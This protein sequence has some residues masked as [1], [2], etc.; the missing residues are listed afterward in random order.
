M[1]VGL[2]LV[3]IPLVLA[4]LWS[5]LPRLF[6]WPTVSSIAQLLERAS[7]PMLVGGIV[8]EIVTAAMF[9]TSAAVY[10]LRV[11]LAGRPTIRVSSLT[12]DPRGTLAE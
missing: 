7:V 1:H 10:L 2:G 11:G 5:V 12:G 8:F 4:K 6:A 9:E 3:P